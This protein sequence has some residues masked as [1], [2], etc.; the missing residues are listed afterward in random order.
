MFILEN[1]GGFFT[2][3]LQNSG[4]FQNIWGD[5]VGALKHVSIFMRAS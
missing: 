4:D 3:H 1:E 2:L 5:Q